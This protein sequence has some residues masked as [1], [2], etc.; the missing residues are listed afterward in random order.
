MTHATIR[1]VICSR[2]AEKKHKY[3]FGDSSCGTKEKKTQN[4]QQQQQ[5]Q[6]WPNRVPTKQRWKEEGNT[7]TVTIPRLEL[8]TPSIF[9]LNCLIAQLL[10]CAF[11]Y[12][13]LFVSYVLLCAS[14]QNVLVF[15][16]CVQLSY[17]VIVSIVDFFFLFIRS[18]VHS[19]LSIRVPFL[20]FCRSLVYFG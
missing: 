1:A 15:F 16:F 18:F 14:Y 6:R 8:Y 9:F 5:W 10:L 11:F 3:W 4:S 17:G 20:F 7:T 19:L 2:T 13:L 12:C